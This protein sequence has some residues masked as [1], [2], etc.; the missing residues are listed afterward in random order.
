MQ[1]SEYCYTLTG[2]AGLAADVREGTWWHVRF[3]TD[4][5]G[6]D[7]VFATSS[8]FVNYRMAF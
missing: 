3:A 4:L 2:E 5:D 7:I 6:A 8:R 1:S